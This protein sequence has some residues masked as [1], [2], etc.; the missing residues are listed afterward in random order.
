MSMT[1][2]ARRILDALNDGRSGYGE[3]LYTI[4]ENTGEPL[5][6]TKTVLTE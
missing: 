6:T 2:L 4:V 1:N 3:D 5:T